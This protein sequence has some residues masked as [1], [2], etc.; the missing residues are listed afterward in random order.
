MEKTVSLEMKSLQVVVNAPEG[1]SDKEILKLAEVE[2]IKQLQ[3]KFPAYS[4]LISSGGS[5]RKMRIYNV[6]HIF[7]TI[8]PFFTTLRKF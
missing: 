2:A 5:V 6:K 1:V 4:Y 3:S 7:L 8:T